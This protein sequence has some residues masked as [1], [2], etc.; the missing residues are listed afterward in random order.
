MK[1]FREFFKGLRLKWRARFYPLLTM[2]RKYAMAVIAIGLYQVDSGITLPLFITA[3][4]VFLIILCVTL[5][6][7]EIKDNVIEISSE[8]SYIIL[9]AFVL[10]SKNNEGL[11]KGVENAFIYLILGNMLL[12]VITNLCKSQLLNTVVAISFKIIHKMY[13]KFLKIKVDHGTS[14]LNKRSK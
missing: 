2:G 7:S 9:I 10:R 1:Y 13:K 6:F 14:R 11:S 8:F 5:P 3:Q 4:V 12:A